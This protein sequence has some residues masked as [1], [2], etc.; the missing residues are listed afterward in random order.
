[1]T[2]TLFAAVALFAVALFAGPIHAAVVSV[3]QVS[4]STAITGAAGFIPVANW[5]NV[6]GNSGSLNIVKDD[7][8][9]TVA[10]MAVTWSSQSTG[11]KPQNS[12]AETQ[13]GFLIEGWGE[14]SGTEGNWTI[15]GIPYASYDLIVYV[16]GFN[17]NQQRD[18][19]I[20]LND[21]NGTDRAF[22]P[23]NVFETAD[24][25]PGAFIE[26]TDTSTLANKVTY[27]GLSGSTLSIDFF[28]NVNNVGV[29]GFQ[30]QGSGAAIPAP[31]AWPAGLA[32]IGLAGLRRRRA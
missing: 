21:D 19:V 5:N 28:P 18:G 22:R 14:K 12:S 31:A 6:T 13:N 7:S 26:A 2:R 4:A 20:R 29:A 27:T 17:T 32:L 10:G 8:G 16:T 11:F 30:I 23:W 9:D 15:T 3:N 25:G 1:M 24:G